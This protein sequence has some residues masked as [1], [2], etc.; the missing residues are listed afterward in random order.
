MK[1]KR[2]LSVLLTVTLLVGGCGST[3]KTSKKKK[4]KPY[5]TAKEVSVLTNLSEVEEVELDDAYYEEH[6]K[7]IPKLVWVNDEVLSS[8]ILIA[9]NDRL[10]REK[11]FVIQMESK[12]I[13]EDD[14]QDDLLKRKEEGVKTDLINVGSCIA[15]ADNNRYQEAVEKGLLEPLDPYLTGEKKELGSHLYETYFKEQWEAM[16]VDGKIYSY[17]WRQQPVS[18]LCAYI[19]KAYLKK[20]NL[21]VNDNVTYDELL[22]MAEKV[23]KKEKR[24]GFCPVLLSVEKEQVADWEIDELTTQ[25]KEHDNLIWGYNQPGMDWSLPTDFFVLYAEENRQDSNENEVLLNEQLL[26]QTQKVVIKKDTYRS[27]TN[28]LTAIAS[29]S[30]HKDEAVEFL[31]LIH[32]NAD[33][34]N[35][36]QYGVEGEN[37]VLENG[38]AVIDE[39]HYGLMAFSIGN[40]WI[41]YPRALEPDTVEE[42]EQWYREYIGEHF[43]E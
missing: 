8:N 36:L 39:E 17:D 3:T 29:W 20:Y 9:L 16:K 42:K 18:D 10:A 7:G 6:W 35:L 40:K 2:V 43:K 28:C 37:Y 41:T 4:L 30:E 11:G 14:Y 5:T 38:K 23:N 13:A 19:N 27:V 24:K 33:Y 31:D 34:A 26:Y 21:I 32:E 15:D 25:V 22:Q 12:S 1:T